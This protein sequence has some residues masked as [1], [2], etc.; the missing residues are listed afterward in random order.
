M[1]VK[2][3]QQLIRWV[4]IIIALIALWHLVILPG[5]N[6]VYQTERIYNQGTYIS[7]S[8]KKKIQMKTKDMDEVEIRAY[9]L[10]F[11]DKK[12]RYSFASQ[13]YRTGQLKCTGYAK[14][15]ADVYNTA[16]QS[17]RLGYRAKPVS[18]DISW[19]GI[20]C[21]RLLTKVLPAK[22][23]GWLLDH[24]F[25]WINKL[26]GNKHIQLDPCFHDLLGIDMSKE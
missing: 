9:S 26:N 20:S 25:V 13:N 14:I 8:E 10:R 5:F 6:N 12:C 21:C 1:Q 7:Q 22:Y 4:I 23:D 19:Y 3:R 15:Y 2:T 17:A 18:G 11:T 16:M 24:D